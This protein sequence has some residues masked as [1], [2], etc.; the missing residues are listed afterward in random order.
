MERVGGLLSPLWLVCVWV[1]R[2]AEGDESNALDYA[3][4]GRRCWWVVLLYA[5]GVVICE[6]LS[7]VDTLGRR[8]QRPED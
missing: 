7:R 8:A 2:F 5:R 4:K 1:K 3:R 6:S